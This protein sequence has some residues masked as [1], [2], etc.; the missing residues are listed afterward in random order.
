MLGNVVPENVG[1]DSSRRF[2]LRAVVASLLAGMCFV[3]D[4]GPV[5]AV[6]GA[7]RVS[8]LHVASADKDLP[9]RDVWVYRPAVPDSRSLPVVDFFAVELSFDA[10]DDEALR[11]CL[12]NLPTSFALPKPTV[13][14]LRVAGEIAAAAATGQFE[15]DVWIAERCNVAVAPFVD[16]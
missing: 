1:E 11:S 12:D 9:V 3:V 5:G 15:F 6:V 16:L 13:D 14:L 8:V 2:V 4:L 10:V 7:G